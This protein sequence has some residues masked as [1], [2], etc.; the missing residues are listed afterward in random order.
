MN[1]NS[2]SMSCSRV[3]GFFHNIKICRWKGK[4][5]IMKGRITLWRTLEIT[6]GDTEHSL[7]DAFIRELKLLVQPELCRQQSIANESNTSYR[8]SLRIF[9]NFVCYFAL[10]LTEGLRTGSSPATA[11]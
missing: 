1:D 9:W 7:N 4:G 5:T 2:W 10:F 3:D 11:N 6:P 8:L